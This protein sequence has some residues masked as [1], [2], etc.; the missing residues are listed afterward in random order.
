MP[1]YRTDL[2]PCP[3]CLAPLTAMGEE[4]GGGAPKAGDSTL[5]AY[6]LAW[7]VVGPP[8]RLMTNQ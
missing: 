1:V 5:C 6:C 7:L 8:L 3:V 2:E 4:T